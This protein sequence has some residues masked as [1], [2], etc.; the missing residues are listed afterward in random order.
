MSLTKSFVTALFKKAGLTIN[1]S[2]EFDPRVH[3]K[4]FFRKVA[5]GGLLGL[6]ESYADGW[7]DCE[8]HGT[9]F[10]RA[11][12]G[13]LLRY[14]RFTIPHIWDEFKYSAFNLQKSSRAFDIGRHHYDIGNDLYKVM[15]DPTMTYSC[16][17]W[18]NAKTL[19]EAQVAK[20][21][22][23]CRKLHLSRGMRVLDI[24]CGNG[25]WLEHAAKNYGV[26]GV[27]V[28]VS[29]E[30]AEYA[31][32]R[33]NGLPVEIRLCDY[34]TLDERFDRIASV[35]MFEHVGW[36]NYV[37]Y[38]NAVKRC[39]SKDG[40]FLLHTI[41]RYTR[42]A[43]IPDPWIRKYIFPGGELPTMDEIDGCIERR[44]FV[45][46]RQE[47]F[48]DYVPTLDAW[49]GNLERGWLALKGKYS[50][51]FYRMWTYYLKMA[52]A[53]FRAGI[54]SVWQIVLAHEQMPYTVVR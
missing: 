44:L 31:R 30:Q 17:Y 10:T 12:S 7:W 11:F 43:G 46:D 9:F 29:K 16:G 49:H 48:L 38:M 6:G 32:E 24:G 13:G 14:E 21:D 51:R 22:L 37:A 41:G 19:E 1:G 47:L 18:Q 34:R 3:N 23:V 4:R 45:L 8:N 20:H 36:H 33:L 50:E 42:S 28:S 15:L 53:A 39:L 2:E 52:E 5:F 27:G 26:N 25:S 40:L 54:I 35:G